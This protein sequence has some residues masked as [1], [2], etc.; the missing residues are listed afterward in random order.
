MPVYFQTN[1]TLRSMNCLSFVRVRLTH[2][3]AGLRGTL[4]LCFPKLFLP[5]S[6]DPLA[7]SL[8][9]TESSDWSGDGLPPPFRNDWDSQNFRPKPLPR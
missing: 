6:Y 3:R 8:E 1:N 7:D 4:R 9:D 5:P 2:L